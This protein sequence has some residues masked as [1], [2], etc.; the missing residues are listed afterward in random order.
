MNCNAAAW[1]SPSTMSLP[2]LLGLKAR[3]ATCQASSPPVG[4]RSAASPSKRP[5]LGV[6]DVRLAAAAEEEEFMRE[7]EFVLSSERRR[8]ETRC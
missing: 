6:G 1:L 3:A 4:A 7:F 8:T 2:K 5:V